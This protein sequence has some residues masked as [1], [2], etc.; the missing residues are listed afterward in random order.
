[1]HLGSRGKVERD[2]IVF[3]FLMHRLSF[4]KK[5]FSM[6]L[7]RLMPI[8]SDPTLVNQLEEKLNIRDCS[9]FASV[10]CYLLQK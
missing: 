8:K 6:I 5:Y 2:S 3:V 7:K 10:S 4:F 1:M 9:L